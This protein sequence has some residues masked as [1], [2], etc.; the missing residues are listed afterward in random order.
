MSLP[1][2]ARSDRD[3]SSPSTVPP[4]Q[5][6]MSACYACF[7]V[8]E[9]FDLIVRA[10]HGEGEGKRSVANLAVASKEFYAGATAVLWEEMDTLVP[11]LTLI[12]YGMWMQVRDDGNAP[13]RSQHLIHSQDWSTSRVVWYGQHIRRLV[14]S[15]DLHKQLP[16]SQAVELLTYLPTTLKLL[17]NLLSFAWTEHRPAVS[18]LLKPKLF[19]NPLLQELSLDMALT[20][21]EPMA[22]IFDVVRSTCPKLS[23]LR[24]TGDPSEPLD[25]A[26]S[27]ALADL[28]R[29]ARL[30]EFRCTSPLFDDVLLA[31]AESASLQYVDIKANW[32][33]LDDM[34]VSALPSR[35]LP[36]VRD[37]SLQFEALDASSLALLEKLG[38]TSLA[39]LGIH[40]TAEVYEND[41]LI[42]HLAVLTKAPFTSSLRKSSSIAG[43]WIPR[44]TA[45]DPASS[46]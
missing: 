8:F 24:L 2:L 9:L 45:A 5:R 35:C 18:R 7:S 28:V 33:T 17:P 34:V 22:T 15:N 44:T 12:P 27:V 42:K 40:I 21:R 6:D 36:S 16:E 26:V 39:N 3:G 10:V 32:Y 38:S 29:T 14:W 19:T 31:V 30:V 11:L 25:V 20:D 4:F 23:R 46:I 37:L 13:Q 1:S 41:M 43:A